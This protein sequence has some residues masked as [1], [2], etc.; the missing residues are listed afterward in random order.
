M[1][2]VIMYK[3]GEELHQFVA[4]S[5]RQLFDGT[6]IS[7]GDVGGFVSPDADVDHDV[8]VGPGC[9][10]FAGGAVKDASVIVGG[11][12][13]RDDATINR[14]Y[15]VGPMDIHGETTIRKV[16]YRSSVPTIR[17]AGT[18]DNLESFMIALT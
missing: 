14:S 8:W 10:V 11:V 15:I 17:D 13:V 3:N 7:V 18:L 5:E 6:I 12:H 1:S 9:Y 4:R 16:M 2:N